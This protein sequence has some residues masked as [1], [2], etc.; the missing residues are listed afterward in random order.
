M[1]S[2]TRDTFFYIDDNNMFVHKRY[3]WEDK[4]LPG[5]GRDGL[6][7]TSFAYIT[8]EEEA[9]LEGLKS[10]IKETSSSVKCFRYPGY[11]VGDCSRDQVSA[12][13][14]AAVYKDL[15]FK[16]SL[17]NKLPY[18]LSKKFKQTPDMW[19]WVQALR[20]N[21]VFELLFL[22]TTLVMTVFRTAWIKVIEKVVGV[23][24]YKGIEDWIK[25]HELKHDNLIH[26]QFEDFA[27][28]LLVW[29]LYVMRDSFLKRLTLK[30]CKWD[31]DKDN[32]L[33]RMMCGEDVEKENIENFPATTCNVWAKKKDDVHHCNCRILSDER[34]ALYKDL[35]FKMYKEK[36]NLI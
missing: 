27:M 14:C 12:L 26:L 2:T 24:K 19:M 35:L 31:I 32:L 25:N 28:Y 5:G 34:N 11:N 21:R 29:Q 20:G 30:V 15:P 6:Y 13:I 16:D 18:R 22:L 4:S 36:Y 9:L 1:F 7:R 17:L 3:D 10:C 8:Y 33:L 23:K